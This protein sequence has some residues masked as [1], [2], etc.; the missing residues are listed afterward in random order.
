L[1]RAKVQRNARIVARTRGF[2]SQAVGALI[3]TVRESLQM[4][5]GDLAAASGAAKQA[6]SNLERGV[7]VPSIPTLE[8]VCRSLRLD[9]VDVIRVGLDITPAKETGLRHQILKLLQDFDS[10]KLELA[11]SQLKVLKDWTIQSIAS[12][13]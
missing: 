13:D 2:K 1:P 10:A 4:S 5:Q 9:P 12:R 11:L 8:A 3:K 7:V 6:I